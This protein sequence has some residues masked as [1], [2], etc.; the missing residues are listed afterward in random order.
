MPYLANKKP[1]KPQIRF[2]TGKKTL[3]TTLYV[4]LATLRVIMTTQFVYKKMY[5][6]V[7]VMQEGDMTKGKKW[8]NTDNKPVPKRK[9]LR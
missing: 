4:R 8:V 1:C 2:K 7:V 6:V 3:S 9:A 5:L